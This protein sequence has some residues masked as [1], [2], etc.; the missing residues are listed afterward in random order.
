MQNMVSD[1]VIYVKGGDQA[2]CILWVPWS[3]SSESELPEPEVP[4]VTKFQMGDQG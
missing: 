1:A 2:M 4:N 3:K